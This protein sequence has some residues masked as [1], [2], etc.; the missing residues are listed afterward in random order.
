VLA[1]ASS[2]PT[3]IGAFATI[4]ARYGSLVPVP[5]SD[6][7]RITAFG[8]LLEAHSAVAGA[9]SADLVRSSSLPVAWFEVLVRLS[10]APEQ[11]LRLTDLAREVC[12]TTSGLSRL[13]DRLEDARLVR[14]EACPSDRRGAYAVLTDEGEAALAAALPPH[15]DSLERHVTEPLGAEELPVLEG[16]LRRL[17]DGNRAAR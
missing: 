8:L 14:R 9:V 11:R 12:L 3:N 17:R 5:G 4:S 13:V 15:L 1:C 6:D 2:S 16:L 7:P 10:R